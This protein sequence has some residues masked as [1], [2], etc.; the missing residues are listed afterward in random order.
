MR[1]NNVHQFRPRRNRRLPSAK[2]ARRFSWG[3]ARLA[4]LGI[5]FAGLLG[6]SGWHLLAGSK[7]S[8]DQFRCTTVRVIDGDTFAC[9]GRRIRLQGIDAPELAGHC[10]PGR[11]CTPG[12]G[13]ASS[14]SLAR[15]VQWNAV[16]CRAVDVDSYGRTVARCT[17]GKKDLSCAQLDAGQA[18]RR[19]GM[20]AC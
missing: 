3:T 18:V 5:A 13:A 4:T 8:A 2:V 20:I 17:A 6:A 9:D 12:D 11:Q 16:Q 10:R 19:Y 14:E 7:G 15:L 1:K